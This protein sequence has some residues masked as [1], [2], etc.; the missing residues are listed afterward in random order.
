[1]SA[2]LTELYGRFILG[3]FVVA[4]L[5]AMARAA[6]AA[7]AETSAHDAIEQAVTRRTSGLVHVGAVRTQVAAE[8]G[9]QA[10]PEPGARTG[11]PARFVLTVGQA[12]RGVAVATVSVT[13]HYARAVRAIARDAE[14]MGEDI[15]AA[16]GE[17]PSVPFGRLP[18]RDEVIGLTARRGIARDE[19]L[20]NGV[21]NRQPLVRSGD[22]V[23]VT[24]TVGAVRVTSTARSSTTGY[25]GDVV[26]IRPHADGRA[27]RA[28]VTGEAAVEVLQ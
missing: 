19:P 21:L 27:V 28:R 20:T 1:M 14:V 10:A 15:D 24:A 17:W 13:G 2:S 8:H 4:V 23:A 22:T 9:L 25:L 16:Y 12:R 26:R 5:L 18:G 11:Q 3:I 6:F 7:P